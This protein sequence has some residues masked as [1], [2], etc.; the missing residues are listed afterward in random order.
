MPT[1]VLPPAG[2]IELPGGAVLPEE[3]FLTRWIQQGFSKLFAPKTP[4]RSPVTPKTT[5]PKSKIDIG[6]RATI[7]AGAVATTAG[8]IFGTSY[9]F[10][11]TP[12]GQAATSQ[13]FGAIN[14]VNR[15]FSSNP[16]VLLALVA[17]GIV[18]VVKK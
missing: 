8:S 16:L 15:F 3:G 11:Q 10:T 14:D 17:L 12:G 6:T 18:L 2:R 5:T 13:A 4:V 1:E 7:G 9:L